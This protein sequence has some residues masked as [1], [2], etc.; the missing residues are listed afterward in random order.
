MSSHLHPPPGARRGPPATARPMLEQLARQTAAAMQAGRL[1]E[2]ARLLRAS[3]DIAPDQPEGCYN[4]G[5]VLSLSQRPA[6]ALPWMRKAAAKL[7]RDPEVQSNLGEILRQLGQLEEAVKC[8]RRALTLSPQNPR[9][10]CNLG[11]TLREA[12]ELE[13]AL[14]SFSTALAREPGLVGAMTGL[15]FTL[16]A[17]QQPAAAAEA[18]R[19]A[20]ALQPDQPDAWNN[21]ALALLSEGRWGEGWDAYERRWS[22][23][24]ANRPRHDHGLPPWQ[25]GKLAPGTGLLVWREQGLGDEIMYASLL[26]DLLAAGLPVTMIADPRLAPLLARSFPALHLPAEGEARPLSA[27]IPCASLP[28]LFRRQAADF[29]GTPYLRADPARVAALR[30]ALPTGGQRIGIAWRSA[31]PN[32][33]EANRRSLPLPRWAPLL[34][35]EGLHWISLQYGG[36][37]EVKAEIGPWP[38]HRPEGLDTLNDIDGLAAQIAALDLVISI[39]NSTVHLAGALGVPC[40]VLLPYSADWRWGTGSATAPWYRS[41]RLYR[42]P[43]PGDWESVLAAVARDLLAW[44]CS[45]Q[46]P[47]AFG[48]PF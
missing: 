16:I 19:R 48:N 43:A 38:L 2:A 37:E 8:H 17:A 42:Q 27:Q 14:A 46:R 36:A 39:D 24:M 30:A 5:L 9:L 35:Q 15:A 6:E 1:E 33:N 31:S 4:L 20:L 3:L 29:P 45:H 34:R 25:G 41:L 11:G 13:K 22:G 23:H 12:G 10:L 18:A 44:S 7:P 40:W 26:P 32:I 47:G 28:R 21:L